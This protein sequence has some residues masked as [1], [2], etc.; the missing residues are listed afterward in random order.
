M[1]SFVPGAE[2]AYIL[3]NQELNKKTYISH[4]IVFYIEREIYISSVVTE[5]SNKNWTGIN[6]R[7]TTTSQRT[8][9][10]QKTEFQNLQKTYYL[11][12]MSNYGTITKI[13]ISVRLDPHLEKCNT[14]HNHH[15]RP[16][17]RLP[18][19]NGC[20]SIPLETGQSM[21]RKWLPYSRGPHRPRRRGILGSSLL[22]R[23]RGRW[24]RD[25]RTTTAI[26]AIRP[27][28]RDDETPFLFRTSR[29]PFVATLH[30]GRN[31]RRFDGFSWRVTAALPHAALPN[32]M[33]CCLRSGW[34]VKRMKW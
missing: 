29:G 32:N 33:R 27:V 28:R 30:D 8:P 21:W 3:K 14:F 24:R 15:L 19:C 6:V 17:S 20:P 9:K 11:P 13:K 18:C 12:K 10:L 26:D 34:F 31:N 1:E 22:H 7:R 2:Q 16:Q 4:I 5:L 25:Y 23:R